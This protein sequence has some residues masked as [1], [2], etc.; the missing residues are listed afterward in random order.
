MPP[1]G[2]AGGGGGGTN[3]TVGSGGANTNLAS[4]P[5]QVGADGL[6]PTER[7]LLSPDYKVIRQQQR[8]I[9]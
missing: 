3:T 4:L 9:G 1:P 7:A 6:T 2:S 5:N 8:G